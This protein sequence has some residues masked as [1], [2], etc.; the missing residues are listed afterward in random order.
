MAAIAVEVAAATG[1]NVAV[2]IDAEVEVLID[3]EVEVAIDV[4]VEVT[5]D[6]EV[7]TTVGTVARRASGT[8][9]TLVMQLR[10]KAKE[11]VRATIAV[12]RRA[13]GKEKMRKERVKAAK[14]AV[15]MTRKAVRRVQKARKQEASR[16]IRDLRMGGTAAFKGEMLRPIKCSRYQ[17]NRNR[18][19]CGSPANHLSRVSRLLRHH[20]IRTT[21][22]HQ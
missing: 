3:V 8:S 5:M 21:R 14:K 4:E 10:G 1:I 6:V 22:W 18:W 11:K 16:I 7:P 17:R 13:R 20:R 2:V 12:A 9:V 15:R 19:R